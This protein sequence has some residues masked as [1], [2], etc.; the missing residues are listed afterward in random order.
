MSL[1][2]KFIECDK[3]LNDLHFFL[4]D[5]A[6]RGLEQNNKNRKFLN[7]N[8]LFGYFGKISVF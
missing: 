1:L 3:Q 6:T 7:Y 8:E 2:E 5:K 4:N